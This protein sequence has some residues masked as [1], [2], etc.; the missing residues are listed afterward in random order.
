MAR[1]LH[2][3]ERHRHPSLRRKVDRWLEV[4]DTDAISKLIGQRSVALLLHIH[5]DDR[6]GVLH[7]H[8]RD[9]DATW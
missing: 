7:V 8:R 6:R 5:L 9:G 1:Q 3:L 2:L 4:H